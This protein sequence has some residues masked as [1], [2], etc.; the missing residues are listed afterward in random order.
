M[1]SEFRADL[2]AGHDGGGYVVLLGLIEK[3]VGVS[4]CVVAR[5]LDRPIGNGLEGS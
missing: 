2:Q 4:E 5:D 3:A 1:D